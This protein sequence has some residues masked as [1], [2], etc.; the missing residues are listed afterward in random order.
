MCAYADCAG[1]VHFARIRSA[2]ASADSVAGVARLARPRCTPTISAICAPAVAAPLAGISWH[3]FCSITARPSSLTMFCYPQR[4]RTIGDERAG[5]LGG[6]GGNRGCNDVSCI[7]DAAF[8]PAPN[9]TGDVGGDR[10]VGLWLSLMF[11]PLRRTTS[12]RRRNWLRTDCR[13]ILRRRKQ[14]ER[15]MRRGGAEGGHPK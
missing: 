12:N 7:L 14:V 2:S 15:T 10:P 8:C 5:M 11:G 9:R 6:G 13:T 4:E 3:A 1:L